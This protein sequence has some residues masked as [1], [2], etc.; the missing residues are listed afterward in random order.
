MTLSSRIIKV[1]L[2]WYD[3]ENSKRMALMIRRISNIL[4]RN[5]I[6]NNRANKRNKNH[7]SEVLQAPFYQKHLRSVQNKSVIRI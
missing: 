3:R 6:V 2:R 1:L 4:M 5:K 7:Q